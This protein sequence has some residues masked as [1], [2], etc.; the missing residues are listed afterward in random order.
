[1][2]ALV[3]PTPLDEVDGLNPARALILQA[4]FALRR[5]SSPTQIGTVQITRWIKAHEPPEPVPSDSLVLLTLRHAKVVHRP[6]GRPRHDPRAPVPA[7]PL[8]LPRRPR[9]LVLGLR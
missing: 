1:M 6:P 2:V 4:Y 7:P 5:T 3:S 9:F 8:F